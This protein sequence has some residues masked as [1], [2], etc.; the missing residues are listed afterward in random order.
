MSD[1]PMPSSKK[2]VVRRITEDIAFAR[3]KNLA[4][5]LGITQTELIIQS[6][7]DQPAARCNCTFCRRMRAQGI[8]IIH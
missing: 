5:R 6:S 7:I 4:A 8:E 1:Q 3:I 2:R